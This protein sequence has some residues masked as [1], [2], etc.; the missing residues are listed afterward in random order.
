MA[1]KDA[2]KRA[3]AAGLNEEGIV[4]DVDSLGLKEA[5]AAQDKID[6]KGYMGVTPDPTPDENYS[7][8][9]PPDAPT[10]E[11]DPDLWLKARAASHGVPKEAVDRTAIEVERDKAASSKSSKEE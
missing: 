8:L 7:T 5:Q 4:T 10:P 9:T 3:K 6:E 2:K 11:T 1:D